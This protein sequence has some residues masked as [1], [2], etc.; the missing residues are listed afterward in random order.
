ML[1]L[2]LNLHHG[3]SCVT[4]RLDALKSIK[5]PMGEAR[6]QLLEHCCCLPGSKL[7]GSFS[8]DHVGF[9]FWSWYTAVLTGILSTR[10]NICLGVG[11]KVA[12]WPD[13]YVIANGTDLWW[14]TTGN[15]SRCRIGQHIWHMFPES[16][17]QEGETYQVKFSWQRRLV[18][19]PQFSCQ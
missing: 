17:N 14:R 8:Q 12:D 5:C 2:S 19:F 11:F 18:Y 13:R 10:L 6:I 3:F 15:H 4:M 16:L 9:I 1:V 7:A